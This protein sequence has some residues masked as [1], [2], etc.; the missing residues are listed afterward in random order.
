[1]GRLLVFLSLPLVLARTV[2]G[3]LVTRVDSQRV[4]AA[5]ADFILANP[6]LSASA[7]QTLNHLVIDTLVP[8]LNRFVSAAVRAAKPGLWVGQDDSLAPYTLR[9]DVNS[10]TDTSGGLSITA[11]WSTCYRAYGRET[12]HDV[13]YELVA[14]NELVSVKAQHL[15]LTGSGACSFGLNRRAR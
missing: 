10:A 13:N 15:L 6:T 1:L 11:T 14:T 5:V 12:G 2:E 8:G 9:F 7:G 4:A 3:Q